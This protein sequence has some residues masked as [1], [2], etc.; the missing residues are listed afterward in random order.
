MPFYTGKSADG[1][2]A[3]EF[4]GF[5]VSPNGKYWGTEPISLEREKELDMHFQNREK[6]V[7]YLSRKKSKYHK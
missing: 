3:K 1:S 5:P 7:R 6:P 4:P 2:D